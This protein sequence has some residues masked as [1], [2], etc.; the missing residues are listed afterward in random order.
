MCLKR[1][2]NVW[3]TLPNLISKYAIHDDHL[4]FKIIWT[5][6]KENVRQQV[7]DCMRQCFHILHNINNN[8]DD[9][10]DDDGS[11]CDD[12]DDDGDNDDD[13]NDDDDDDD[14]EW[15]HWIQIWI[16]YNGPL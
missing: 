12:Y 1:G 7:F 14:D 3:A 10:D 4:L 6:I 11:G 13:D 8:N 16:I 9:D 5:K 15:I 2:N